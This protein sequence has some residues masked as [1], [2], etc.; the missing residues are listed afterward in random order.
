[1]SLGKE[2]HSS[3][4]V[5]LIPGDMSPGKGY[6][7]K[8]NVIGSL[9]TWLRVFLPL[10]D[11]LLAVAISQKLRLLYLTTGDINRLIGLLSS[12]AIASFGLEL[13]FITTLVTHPSV[14]FCESNHLFA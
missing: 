3:Y 10:T 14:R 13:A 4:S 5:P 7:H 6:N 12:P 11:A 2:S 8:P 1:M 9:T